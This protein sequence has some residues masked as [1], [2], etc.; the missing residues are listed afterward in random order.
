MRTT[1]GREFLPL[2][3]KGMLAIP[4]HA[5]TRRPGGF[6]RSAGEVGSSPF[7]GRHRANIP[8]M[9]ACSLILAFSVCQCPL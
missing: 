9:L 3:L 1:W 4:E 6:P 2:E 8:G 7:H 5:E